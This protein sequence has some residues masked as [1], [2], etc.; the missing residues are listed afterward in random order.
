M[1]TICDMDAPA[2]LAKELSLKT[3]PKIEHQWKPR[4]QCFKACDTLY[5]Q[6]VSFKCWLQWANEK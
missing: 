5:C 6:P 3:C 4:G 1:I 2:R